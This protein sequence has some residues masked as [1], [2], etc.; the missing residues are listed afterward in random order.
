MCVII[1]VLLMQYHRTML[2]GIAYG[3]K[4]TNL[5]SCTV[6]LTLMAAATRGLPWLQKYI[7][8]TKQFRCSK[9]IW[10]YVLCVE[11]AGDYF[12]LGFTY[13]SITP[14]LTKTCAKKR[15]P[16]FHSQW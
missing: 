8:K 5:T 1:S 6:Q 7:T 3:E 13:A 11:W 14:L 16:R 9:C 15:F 10:R 2:V 4:L 12:G